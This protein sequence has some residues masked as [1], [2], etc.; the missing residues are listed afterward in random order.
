MPAFDYVALD[1]G[2]RK[3]KGITEGDSPRQ[4]RQQLRDQQLTPLQVNETRTQ[5]SSSGRTATLSSIGDLLSAG[6]Q[7][8]G[9]ELAL[10][11]RQIATLLQA[12]LSVEESL[13]VIGRQSERRNTS[14]VV[15]AVRAKVREGF[16]FAES[17]KQH[18][19]T[20]NTLYCATVAAGEGSG[21]LDTVMLRLA[22]YTESQQQFLQKVQMAMVYPILLMLLSL[23][24]VSGLMIYVVPDMVQVITDAGQQLPLLTEILIAVSEFLQR[25]LLPLLVLIVVFAMVVRHLLQRPQLRLRWH[26]YK[27]RLP[28]FGKIQ[29]NTQAARYISTLAILTN[30]GIPLVEA[31]RIAAP[32]TSNVHFQQQLAECGQRVREGISLNQAL[33]QSGLFPPMM[34][35]LIISGESSGELPTMLQ[36]AAH[37]QENELQR[38]VTLLV[39]I[40]EPA[41]LVA[42]GGF[43]LLIVLAVMLPILNMNQMVS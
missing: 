6:P 15:L 2:G 17:L 28:L 32:V 23:I 29:R 31:M 40:L 41:T 30:S 26:R 11:T 13:S 5:G 9:N 39:T 16:S 10:V 4:V 35:Q 8:S 43:V 42:M 12:G 27:L 36:K 21:H 19:R 14:R 20:F 24:I 1:R 22:D 37:I 25:G 38:M 18:P 7:L 33:E 34:L 3:R